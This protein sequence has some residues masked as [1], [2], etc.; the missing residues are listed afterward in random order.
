[1]RSVLLFASSRM[2]E[3]PR[4]QCRPSRVSPRTPA[5]YNLSQP[6]PIQSPIARRVVDFK[7]AL[8]QKLSC[9]L[10]FSCFRRRGCRP[11][12]LRTTTPPVPARPVPARWAQTSPALPFWIE[13]QLHPHFRFRHYLSA[14]GGHFQ[15][16]R[17]CRPRDPG[18]RQ[19]RRWK[20]CIHVERELGRL[21]ERLSEYA[22]G[23]PREDDL[24]NL[25][26]SR[27]QQ[28]T[29]GPLSFSKPIPSRFNPRKDGFV[30]ASRHP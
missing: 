13:R 30:L 3:P 26:D 20:W 12:K 9:W 16:E 11:S 19:D 14:F 8:C 24:Q 1:M 21:H 18:E 10:R 7:E 29:S 17:A 25:Q 23:R 15:A 2:L 22:H 28:I 5:A 27:R 6:S 4:S